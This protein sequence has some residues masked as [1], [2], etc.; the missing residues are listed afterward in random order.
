MWQNSYGFT[1]QIMKIYSNQIIIYP[2]TKFPIKM[3]IEI[4]LGVTNGTTFNGSIISTVGEFMQC[5]YSRSK[6]VL[7]QGMCP[8]LRSTWRMES[9]VQG[10]TWCLFT[11]F[12]LGH[13]I[14]NGNVDLKV[15]CNPW[16]CT[17]CGWLSKLYVLNRKDSSFKW[18]MKRQGKAQAHRLLICYAAISLDHTATWN[19]V[20]R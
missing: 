5:I 13:D 3:D 16:K 6:M 11:W 12:S 20:C 4:F 7:L 10:Y 14:T 18:P 2:L 17:P 9:L 15:R 19:F 8:R 1:N